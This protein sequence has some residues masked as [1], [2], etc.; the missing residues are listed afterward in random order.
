MCPCPHLTHCHTSTVSGLP[1]IFLCKIRPDLAE[2]RTHISSSCPLLFV[3][4]V[5][6][7]IVVVVVV[8]D[9]HTEVVSGLWR[10]IQFRQNPVT[11]RCCS[12]SIIPI[13]PPFSVI[14][15]MMR[16]FVS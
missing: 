7:V 1:G 14:M 4:V 16:G 13:N 2:V 15:L 12:V 10:G 6:V 8:V 5:V 11:V 9:I 3:V